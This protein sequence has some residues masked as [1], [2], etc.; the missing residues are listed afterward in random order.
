MQLKP[1]RHY[2]R[3]ILV[4]AGLHENAVPHALAF[5]QTDYLRE[6][7]IKV[8]WDHFGFSLLEKRP[9]APH[10]FR[11][12]VA[13]PDDPLGG[14]IRLRQVRWL[15]KQPPKA[16]MTVGYN[17]CEWLVHFV[18]N[19]SCKLGDSRNLH[20]LR[21]TCLSPAQ[22]LRCIFPVFDVRN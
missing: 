6:H 11:S 21:K 18:R 13:V 5:Q 3:Q 15:R 17:S 12:A 1:I 8:E 19:R 4:Q 10:D 16:R 20:R 2:R 9:D 22:N 7:L 14:Q